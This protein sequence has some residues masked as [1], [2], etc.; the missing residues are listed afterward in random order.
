MLLTKNHTDIYDDRLIRSAINDYS[1]QNMIR[2][3]VR[4]LFLI[5]AELRLNGREEPEEADVSEVKKTVW[6]YIKEHPQD[7]DFI[8]SFAA[9]AQK[10]IGS[11]L[12]RILISAIIM[13]I[14][15]RRWS[16]TVCVNGLEN[17]SIH[18]VETQSLPFMAKQQ[19]KAESV[20][21][22]Y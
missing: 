3:H 6:R 5:I 1:R 20:F 12:V 11:G 7:S 4:R 14:Q 2:E 8:F 17:C 22:C 21:S 18:R 9:E 19:I 10:G 16:V 13:V 15:E